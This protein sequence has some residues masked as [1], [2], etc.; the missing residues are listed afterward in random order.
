MK[1]G[2]WNI[3]S[4]G[5]NLAHGKD[6]SDSLVSLI[7]EKEID[8]MCIA[9][10][11][12]DVIAT[13][14]AKI[15]K[16]P[17]G[18]GYNQVRNFKDKVTL[19]SNISDGDFK[20]C[21]DQY[22]STRWA[23]HFISIPGKLDF[24][25]FTV[26]F[27]SKSNWSDESQGFECVN[28]SRDIAIVES[29]TGCDNTIVVGD[30]NMNPFESGMVAANALHAIPDLDYAQRHPQGR[31]ID[32]TDYRFFYNPMWNFFG[33]YTSPVGT[34][35]FRASGHVA[36]E[37]HIFDQVIFRPTLKQLLGND[38]VQ[39]IQEIDNDSLVQGLGR[40]DRTLYSDHLPITL[41][42]SV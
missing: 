34:Y 36:Y 23:S 11:N 21:G 9:E 20:D 18:Q 12:D 33:D 24:N 27:H 29:H 31:E 39:I 15:Q 28:L 37:W 10:A 8:I 19:I 25:L 2:F 41:K 14:L 3:D 6:L 1:I 16:M 35:Y 38:Y 7:L 42:I 17:S 26:H 32:G 30:F 22:S 4:S 40:P 13:V 5:N